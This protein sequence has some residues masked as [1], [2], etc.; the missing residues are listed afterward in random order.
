V[1]LKLLIEFKYNQVGAKKEPDESWIP[2]DIDGNNP[3]V[4][5]IPGTNDIYPT[6][7]LEVGYQHETY[8]ELLRDAAAKHFSPMTSIQLYLGIKIHR[9][10]RRFQTVLCDRA[11]RNA[12]G[13]N[14]LFS[15][16]GMLSVDVPTPLSFTLPSRLL[17]FGVPAHLIPATATPDL[18]VPLERIRIAIERHL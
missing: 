17:F 6:F 8:P 18:V 4:R 2:R 14:I 5:F 13:T 1:K 9:N 10:S 3:N 16:N 7:V 12:G 15:T 11:P